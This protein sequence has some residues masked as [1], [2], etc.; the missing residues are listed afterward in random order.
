[1]TRGQ[2]E[3][4]GSRAALDVRIRSSKLLH[5]GKH[6][7]A[8]G[9]PTTTYTGSRVYYI[10]PVAKSTNEHDTEDDSGTRARCLLYVLGR[11]SPAQIIVYWS[12]PSYGAGI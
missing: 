2:V 6:T 1:M 11:P 5:V 8:N 3:E 4:S 9:M 10:V 7:L 12:S